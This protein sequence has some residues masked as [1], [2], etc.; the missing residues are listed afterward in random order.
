MAPLTISFSSS[1]VF[2]FLHFFLSISF[3]FYPICCS[4]HSLVFF[5]LWYYP[6]LICSQ[7]PRHR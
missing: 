3:R 4:R 2:Y 6:A 1:I 5:L 7:P